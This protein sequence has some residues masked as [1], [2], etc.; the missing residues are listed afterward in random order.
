MSSVNAR[1]QGDNFLESSL[2]RLIQYCPALTA[3]Y[4]ESREITDDI[5]PIIQ[6]RPMRILQLRYAKVT[7]HNMT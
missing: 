2:I 3:L 7:S 6:Q 5:I 4:M 1:W